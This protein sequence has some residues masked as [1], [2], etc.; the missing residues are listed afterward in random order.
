MLWIKSL[1]IAIKYPLIKQIA[2]Q[3][4][5]NLTYTVSFPSTVTVVLNCNRNR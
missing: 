3:P 2:S 5:G 4:S 1:S